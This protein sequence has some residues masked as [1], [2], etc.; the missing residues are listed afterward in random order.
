MS[1]I[2]G[3]PLWPEIGYFKNNN[4]N[5]KS[6][7]IFRNTIMLIIKN[8]ISVK[9]WLVRLAKRRATVRQQLLVAT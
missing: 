7:R 1:P 3:L 2:R 6:R 8:S 5:K 4:H 9:R